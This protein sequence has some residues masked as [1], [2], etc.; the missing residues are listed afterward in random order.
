MIEQNAAN[1]KEL[2]ASKKI[3]YFSES[4]IEKIDVKDDL[5]LIHFK[6]NKFPAIEASIVVVALGA[7]RPTNYL[8]TIGIDTVMESGEF[9]SESKMAG[10]FCVGDLASGKGGGSINFAFNSGVKAINQ[11]CDMYLD[12]PY[13]PPEKKIA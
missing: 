9:F 11:A 2:I 13:S 12:C 1:T 4:Q 10:L 7:E 6:G 8:N 3:T 5:P